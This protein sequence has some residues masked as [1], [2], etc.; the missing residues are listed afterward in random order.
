MDLF[1]FEVNMAR[2]ANPPKYVREHTCKICIFLALAFGLKE[3][4]KSQIFFRKEAN[5][6]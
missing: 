3:R 6:V 4:L 5:L 1:Y 2:L